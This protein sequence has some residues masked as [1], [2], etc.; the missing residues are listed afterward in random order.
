MYDEK[1][2]R[3]WKR[4]CLWEREVGVWADIPM[5]SEVCENMEHEP[6]TPS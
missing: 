1:C 2:N 4:V 6:R 3:D 5:R